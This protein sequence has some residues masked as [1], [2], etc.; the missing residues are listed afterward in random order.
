M[1]RARPVLR[2][3]LTGAGGVLLISS[4]FLGLVATILLAWLIVLDFPSHADREAGSFLALIAAIAITCGAG[5]YSTLRGAPLFPRIDAKRSDRR[6][7]P[8]E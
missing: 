3:L 7:E 6:P 4:L 8:P 5:D 2:R 1:T